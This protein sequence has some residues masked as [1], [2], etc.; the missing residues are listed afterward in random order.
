HIMHLRTKLGDKD[1]QMLVTVRGKGYQ[2]LAD[3]GS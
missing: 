3:V 2:F 1:Q